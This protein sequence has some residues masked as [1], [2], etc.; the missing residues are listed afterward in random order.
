PVGL[1]YNLNNQNFKVTRDLGS[2]EYKQGEYIYYLD[3]SVKVKSRDARIHNL[4]FLEN[5]KDEVFDRVKMNDS[6]MYVHNTYPNNAFGSIAD[7]YLGYRNNDF[8]FFVYDDEISVY[9]YGY[10]KNSNLEDWIDEYFDN[11][12][13]E[14]FHY[15]LTSNYNLYDEYEYDAQ[16]KDLHITYPWFG[17][18]IDIR[19][20]KDVKIDLYSNYKFTERTAKLVGEGRANLHDTEDTLLSYETKRRENE[21]LE[22]K[23]ER[24]DYKTTNKEN[25]EEEKNEEKVDTI[26]IN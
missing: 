17:I 14:D 15:N 6:L 13:L 16:K 1:L 21:S 19:A 25:E 12:N 2:A 8:Y 7:G 20:G 5:Y 3:N 26:V 4:V 22:Y 23:S 24:I 10:Q 9:G 18:N 11:N